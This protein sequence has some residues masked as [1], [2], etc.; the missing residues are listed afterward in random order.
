MAKLRG[1]DDHGFLNVENVFIP[2]QIDPAC[3][4]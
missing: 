1:F 2:K 3:P 4:A